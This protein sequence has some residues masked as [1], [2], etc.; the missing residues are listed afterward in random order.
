MPT[1]RK[2]G[3]AFPNRLKVNGKIRTV[4]KRKFCLD[5]SP[6]G[7]RNSRDL[8]KTQDLLTTHKVCGKCGLTKPISE[9]YLRK[10]KSAFRSDC[11]DCFL[12]NQYQNVRKRRRLCLDLKGG[13]CIVCGYDRCARS[14]ALH[15]LDPTK[16]DPAFAK[17]LGH[18]NP[19]GK[20]KT[21][22]DKC[23]L[24]CANCHGEIHS[25]LIDLATLRPELFIPS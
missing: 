11:K 19:N 21:E 18:Y 6:F 13:K 23:V 2:C 7:G 25:G 14:L 20:A 5:C 22:L 9:F 10:D 12:K 3:Q 15:H 8:T 17:M 4:D 24:V 1:C 16:K